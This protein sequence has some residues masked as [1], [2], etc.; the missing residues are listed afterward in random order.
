MAGASVTLAGIF[1]LKA[2]WQ[3]TLE[4]TATTRSASNYSPNVWLA[5]LVV[6]F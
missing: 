4:A 5:Q 2:E 3:H 6:V 1:Q